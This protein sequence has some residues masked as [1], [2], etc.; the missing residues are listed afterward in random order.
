M[1]P[2]K[3]R[4]ID[5]AAISVGLLTGAW[6]L[7]Y[8]GAVWGLAD[9]LTPGPLREYVMGP[10][11][12]FEI[13]ISGVGLGLLLAGINR[14]SES[15]RFRRWSFGRL[16]VFRSA[17]YVGGLLVVAGLVNLALFLFVYSA[18]ELRTVAGL[19][20]P[21]LA[22]SLGLWIAATTL[23]VNFLLEVRRKV[24]PGQL[25]ALMTGRYQR[26]RSEN[27]VF[28][29]V[30]LKG[31]TTIAET[32]GHERY[33]RLLQDCFHELS[34]AVLRFGAQIYQYVGD[35]VV[36]TWPADQED[37]HSLCIQTYFAF[38]DRLDAKRPWYE[39]QFGVAPEFR[40]GA[41]SGLV[42]AAEVGD[43]KR[44]IAY[45]GDPLNTA[46]RLQELC[47]A[48]GQRILVSEGVGRGLPE[49]SGFK[50][51]WQGNVRLRGKAEAVPVYGVERETP[52]GQNTSKG[53]GKRTAAG[54]DD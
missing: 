32:L 11:I 7:F 52:E 10:G 50:T 4:F 16:I 27:R 1:N 40:A 54:L 6:Y 5:D 14:W 37:A 26:P 25:T 53:A 35:E 29:F 43:V 9:Q 8:L 28:L 38:H 2:S 46:A 12:H 18:E 23:A 19:L 17:C 24:G 3:R 31:S 51:E 42:T 45:H 39:E 21:R 48:Y 30:D 34:D 36:L 33:S 20:S 22:I 15:P 44:E 49:H 47:K 41:E 13:L